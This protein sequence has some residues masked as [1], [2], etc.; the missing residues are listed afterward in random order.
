MSELKRL[1]IDLA[2]QPDL[3]KAYKADPE[4]VMR[5][6]RLSDEA[7]AAMLAKDV[8]TIKRLSGLDSI[9]SNGTIQAHDYR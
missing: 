3:Q 9:R 4:A 1:L 5:S 7:I 8:E 2:E 6:Y